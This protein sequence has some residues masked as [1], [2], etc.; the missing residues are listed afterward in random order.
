MKMWVWD[1]WI[2]S[3]Y[4]MKLAG[5]GKNRMDGAGDEIETAAGDGRGK[6]GKVCV[7]IVL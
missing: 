3:L 1:G 2:G 4:S 6:G 5:S 7:D